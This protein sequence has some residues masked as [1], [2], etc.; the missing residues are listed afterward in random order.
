MP[1]G[2]TREEYLQNVEKTIKKC[3]KY[4]LNFSPR[5]QIVIWDTKRG[6]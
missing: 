4:K 2:A 5:L 6:V 3:L 1:L